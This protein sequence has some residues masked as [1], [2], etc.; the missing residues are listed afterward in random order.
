[1]RKIEKIINSIKKNIGIYIN[2]T[3]EFNNILNNNCIISGNF[4]LSHINNIYKYN[5]INHNTDIIDMYCTKYE[6][7]NLKIF[8]INNNFQINE[9]ENINL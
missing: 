8:L 9:N 5:T 7:L 2:N 3:Y 6:Y 1:M 4:I